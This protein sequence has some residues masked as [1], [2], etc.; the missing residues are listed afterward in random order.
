MKPLEIAGARARA[1]QETGT[2]SGGLRVALRSHICEFQ[3]KVDH[4]ST[5]LHILEWTLATTNITETIYRCICPCGFA[6]LQMT[7]WIHLIVITS[8]LH[9]PGKTTGDSQSV[10]TGC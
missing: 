10:V 1:R 2:T 4:T 6:F 7:V 8:G 9:M 5:A 3:S